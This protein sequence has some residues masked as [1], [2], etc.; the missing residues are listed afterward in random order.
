MD[1]SPPG[2]SVHGI[3]QARVLEWAA[4]SSSG[5]ET[6]NSSKQSVKPSAPWGV[7]LPGQKCHPARK[8]EILGVYAADP[9]G[10]G[11][12]GLGRLPLVLSMDAREAF[13]AKYSTN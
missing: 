6:V 5:E 9:G 2:S 1:C 7:D 10:G 11:G 13:L 8:G 3:L 4:I 12:G